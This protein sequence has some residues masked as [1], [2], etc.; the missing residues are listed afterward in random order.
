MSKKQQ[1]KW[2]LQFIEKHRKIG[3]IYNEK[4]KPGFTLLRQQTNRLQQMP[5]NRHNKVVEQE[6]L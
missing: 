5:K 1:N 6:K 4:F 2:Q 3:G